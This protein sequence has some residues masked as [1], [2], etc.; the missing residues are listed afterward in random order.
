MNLCCFSVLSAARYGSCHH[1]V[2]FARIILPHAIDWQAFLCKNHRKISK[3][4]LLDL[5][6]VQMIVLIYD[7]TTVVFWSY[8][9][10]VSV[11]YFQYGRHVIL[12]VSRLVSWFRVNIITSIGSQCCRLECWSGMEEGIMLWLFRFR[13]RENACLTILNSSH[14]QDANIAWHNDFMRLWIHNR[15][16]R[17]SSIIQASTAMDT[18]MNAPRELLILLNREFLLLFLCLYFFFKLLTRLIPS[19]LKRWRFMITFEWYYFLYSR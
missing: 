14:H 15:V 12:H 17:W 19:L 13:T 3:L 4:P 6:L 9:R 2:M 11:L 1:G 5:N 10:I 8:T 16:V 7:G 18:P